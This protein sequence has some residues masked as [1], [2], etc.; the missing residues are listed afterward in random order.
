[1]EIKSHNLFKMRGAWIGFSILF[2]L[3]L[4]FSIK[5]FGCSPEYYSKLNVGEEV[6]F[7]IESFSPI[8]SSNCYEYVSLEYKFCNH[9]ANGDNFDFKDCLDNPQKYSFEIGGE[10]RGDPNTNV[11]I[12][13]LLDTRL[14]EGGG[15]QLLTV[16]AIV[17]LIIS[18]SL[19]SFIG[20][21]IGWGIHSLIRK[22][23]K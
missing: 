7:G 9:A 4:I 21:L 15:P 1:M 14:K 3:F 5:P 22:S 18:I 6:Y 8:G 23:K 19:F 2:I 20:F 11:T 16:R 10:L 17:G 13:N 12:E